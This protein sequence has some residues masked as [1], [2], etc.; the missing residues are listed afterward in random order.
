MLLV[1]NP[2]DENSVRIAQAYQQIRAIPDSNIVFVS[3]RLRKGFFLQAE[4][5]TQGSF[6]YVDHYLQPISSHIAAHNLSGQID[7]IAGLGQPFLA[8]VVLR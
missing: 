4:R 2:E 6:S 7:Y 8:A 3:P 5:E 1:V